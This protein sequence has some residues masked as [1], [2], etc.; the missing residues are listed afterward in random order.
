LLLDCCLLCSVCQWISACR[1]AVCLQ[2]FSERNRVFRVVVIVVVGGWLFSSGARWLRAEMSACGRELVIFSSPSS[3]LCSLA[4]SLRDRFCFGPSSCACASRGQGALGCQSQGVVLA[5]RASGS[6]LAVF[7]LSQCSSR[8]YPLLLRFCYF[9]MSHDH[10]CFRFCDC[11]GGG[12]CIFFRGL[13]VV[14]CRHSIVAAVPARVTEAP[15]SNSEEGSRCLSGLGAL[16]SGCAFTGLLVTQAGGWCCDHGLLLSSFL[17]GGLP[18]R[19]FTLQ[20]ARGAGTRELSIMSRAT[21]SGLVCAALCRGVVPPLKDH[22]HC[23]LVL[24]LFWGMV[25]R[26]S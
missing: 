23:S 19:F 2:S 13:E 1:G 3:P 4:Q 17:V 24:C 18:V 8:F 7:L 25:C 11:R 12:A 21:G 26:P 6:G 10:A 15:S 5:T 20:G 14:L 9:A 22:R 16:C